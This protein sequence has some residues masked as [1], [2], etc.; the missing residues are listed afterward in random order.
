MS[1][2]KPHREAKKP[3]AKKD[4]TPAVTPRPVLPVEH[5]KV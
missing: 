5:H 1:K 4:K 3:K 2:D